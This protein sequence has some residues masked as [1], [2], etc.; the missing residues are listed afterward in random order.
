MKTIL[1]TGSA[2]RVGAFLRKQLRDKYAF[3]LSD[4]E[5]IVDHASNERI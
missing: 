4:R 1:M 5:G 3:R 2:G